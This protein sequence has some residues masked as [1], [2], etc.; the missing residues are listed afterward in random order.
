MTEIVF[1]NP[2][3]SFSGIDLR[4]KAIGGTYSVTIMLAETLS[5]RGYS[6]TVYN[7]VR[8]TLN[9]NNVKYV[10][11]DP[12]ALIH[13]EIAVS[14]NSARPLRNVTS[15]K[16]I[17]WQH[18]R[19]DWVRAFKRRE[20]WRLLRDRP[21]VVCLSPDA[22]RKTSNTMPY[23]SKTFIQHGIEP[24]FLGTQLK[25]L[26]PSKPQALFAS[27]PHRGLDWLLETWKKH[28]LPDVPNAIL[29]VCTPKPLSFTKNEI[30]DFKKYNVIH[31]GSVPQSKVAELMCTC[32]ALLCPGHKNETGCTVALQS[33]ASGLPIVTS[34][35]GCL[36]DQVQHGITGF[37]ETDPAAY[38]KRAA[39]CLQD[40]SL[41][42]KLHH[43]SL[44]SEWIKDWDS[45]ADRWEQM[46]LAN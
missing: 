31:H 45:V 18:N 32:R 2:E 7:G 19:T 9:Y 21:D 8:S 46:F 11:F 38:A 5:K 12:D 23:R 4:E 39:T 28:I 14:G 6:V 16:K 37:I 33:I 20:L 42:M 44:K 10:P 41:W 40:D 26:A 22:V 43:N 30:E 35:H 25:R 29:N 17:V 1:L 3:H 36:K 13:A 15:R 24:V 34:G 27:R